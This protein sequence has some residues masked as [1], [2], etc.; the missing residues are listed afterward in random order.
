[1]SQTARLNLGS[2]DV[3]RRKTDKYLNY[4]IC[5]KALQ[6]AWKETKK[7]PLCLDGRKAKVFSY[8]YVQ[9]N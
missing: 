3:G 8:K 7:V 5:R 4:Y 2:C 6:L 9:K 1:M